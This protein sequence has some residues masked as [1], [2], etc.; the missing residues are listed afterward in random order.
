MIHIA[1]ALAAAVLMVIAFMAAG[2]ML[3]SALAAAIAA[4]LVAWIS[5]RVARNALS[6]S[7]ERRR[8]AQHQAAVPPP[9]V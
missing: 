8:V 9:A 7:A 4:G 5:Y 3:V 2:I 6:R 1:S